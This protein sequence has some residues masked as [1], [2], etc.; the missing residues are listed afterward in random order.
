MHRGKTVITRLIFWM[1]ALAVIY[2]LLPAHPDLPGISRHQV[3]SPQSQ[4]RQPMQNGSIRFSARFSGPIEARLIL[5]TS[6]NHRIVSDYHRAEVRQFFTVSIPVEAQNLSGNYAI[7]W[8]T[9]PLSTLM[10]ARNSSRN[11]FSP[12]STFNPTF[13]GWIYSLRPFIRNG[14]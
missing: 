4:W 3:S 7:W 2:P 13:S 5:E 14:G 11:A 8:E 10:M 9:R 12:Q 1:I 6:E